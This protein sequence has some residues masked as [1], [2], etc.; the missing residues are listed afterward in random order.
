MLERLRELGI[1]L[2][3]DDFGTGYS[4]LT[5]LHDLPLTEVKIDRSFVMNSLHDRDARAI[6]GGDGLSLSVAAACWSP[7]AAAA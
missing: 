5:E 1:G 6:V 3:I 7:S 4:S 2:S